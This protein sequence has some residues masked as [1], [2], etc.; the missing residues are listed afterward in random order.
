MQIRRLVLQRCSPTGEKGAWWMG[1]RILSCISFFFFCSKKLFYFSFC[2]GAASLRTLLLTAL[3][4]RSMG[5]T[6]IARCLWNHNSPRETSA[7]LVNVSRQ[8]STAGDELVGPCWVCCLPQAKT[9][10]QSSHRAAHPRWP[11]TN[12]PPGVTRKRGRPAFSQRR[13]SFRNPVDAEV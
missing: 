8:R 10:C 4:R 1:Q 3:G 9:L 5:A 7:P 2:F 6:W 12:S 11:K 13:C